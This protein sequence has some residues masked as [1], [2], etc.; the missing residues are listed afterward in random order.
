MNKMVY[1]NSEN[2]ADLKNVFPAVT[3]SIMQKALDSSDGSIK[4]WFSNVVVQKEAEF[5]VVLTSLADSDL[6]IHTLAMLP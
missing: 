3:F 4:L 2:L 6:L 1:N 5:V